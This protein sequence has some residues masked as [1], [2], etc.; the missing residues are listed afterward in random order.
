MICT[1]VHMYVHACM[2]GCVNKNVRLYACAH[3]N[4]GY[5]L[6]PCLCAGMHACMHVCGNSNS[7]LKMEAELKC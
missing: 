1:Y 2:H 6:I 3:V 4:G 5:G 7:I